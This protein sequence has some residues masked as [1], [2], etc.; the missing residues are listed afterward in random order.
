[1]SLG[2]LEKEKGVMMA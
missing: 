1:V 2:G